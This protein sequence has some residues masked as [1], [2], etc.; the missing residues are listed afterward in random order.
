M[1]GS[2]ANSP[3][4]QQGG[5]Q[6]QN[7][8]DTTAKQDFNAAMKQASNA[9][10]TEKQAGESSQA[11]DARVEAAAN[12]RS[13]A[14]SKASQTSYVSK[15]AAEVKETIATLTKS[16]DRLVTD[17]ANSMNLKINFEGGGSVNLRISMDGSAV[18]TQM[19]TDVVGLEAVIKANWAE[20]AN[21]WNQKGV[22]LNS[23]HFQNSESSKDNGFENLNEFASKGDRQAGGRNGENRGQGSS[24]GSA[25]R[26]FD[27]GA[28][29]SSARGAQET[30]T[31]EVV[32]DSKIKTYA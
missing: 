26:G 9:K 29:E 2:P 31:E 15:T 21:D 17:K 1:A 4:A 23:P 7:G 6:N 8:G 27:S 10:G 12:R 5:S 3:T 14:A 28:T 20:L 19:Q 32:S 24:R 11:F 22:K 18:S 13:E 30:A 25:S 16:I